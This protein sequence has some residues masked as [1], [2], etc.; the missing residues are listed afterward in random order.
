[1]MEAAKLLMLVDIIEIYK[2]HQNQQRTADIP[3]FAWL[4]FARESSTTPADLIKN[5]LNMVGSTGGLEQV[6]CL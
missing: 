6:R 3:V 2:Q 5:H 1:M 4:L